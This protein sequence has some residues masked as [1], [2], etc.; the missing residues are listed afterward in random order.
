VKKAADTLEGKV[1]QQ[2]KG[3]RER[4]KLDDKQSWRS[5]MPCVMG[6]L[7]QQLY[8][9]RPKLSILLQYWKRPAGSIDSYMTSLMQCKEKVSEAFTSA[10]RSALTGTQHRMHCSGIRC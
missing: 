6:R 4:L 7:S 9:Y 10:Q 2:W 1:D 8:P 5:A 3:I